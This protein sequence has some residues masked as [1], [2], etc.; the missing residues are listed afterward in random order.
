MSNAL[1][2]QAGRST[3]STGVGDWDWDWGDGWMNE[4]VEGCFACVR[5]CVLC[6]GRFWWEERSFLYIYIYSYILYI[7]IYTIYLQYLYHHNCT[8]AEFVFQKEQTDVLLLH[9]SNAYSY[10]L[11]TYYHIDGI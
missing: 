1:V 8:I 11:L 3:N 2:P 5:A 7:C 9:Y 10:M 4:W 6:G